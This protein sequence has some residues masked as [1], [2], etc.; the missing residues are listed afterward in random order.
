MDLSNKKNRNELKAFFKKNSIPTES[1]FADL[2]DGALNQKED[3]IAKLPNNPLSI[4]ADDSSQKNVLALYSKLPDNLPT[5]T[6]SLKDSGGIQDGLSINDTNNLS[7]LFIGINGNIGIGISNPSEKL[8][9]SGRLKTEEL[10][11]GTWPANP[12]YIF[13]GANSLNQAQA[14]NYALLQGT[15]G[16]ENG[17]TFLNS[18]LDVR[19]R[20]ANADKLI[21]TNNGLDVNGNVK[22]NGN[23]QANS[24]SIPQENW[25]PP[26]LLN[27]WA[28]YANTFNTAGYFKDSF[29]IVHLKG[30]V[31]SGPANQ[32][33]FTL[34]NGYRPAQRELHAVSTNPNTIGRIDILT[35]GDV[36]MISGNNEWISL[37][38]ITFRAALAIF[39]PPIFI[40][41]IIP[42]L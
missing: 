26:P 19:I 13:W 12:A 5:W 21:I 15:T 10:T 22:V 42:H 38:G 4:E 9:I 17:R 11:T 1:N 28:N 23:L 27:S 41:P 33:I 3:G 8:E 39:I 7:R 31:R 2:I 30:L 37:D 6:L 16:G 40:D 29:G 25:I 14:G 32:P 18:P 36:I 34:P 20:I 35:N 24:I